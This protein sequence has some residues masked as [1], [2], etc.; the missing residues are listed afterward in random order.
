MNNKGFL[1]VLKNTVVV[2]NTHAAYLKNEKHQQYEIYDSCTHNNPPE[3]RVWSD[4]QPVRKL[5]QRKQ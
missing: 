4:K 5:E 2:S 3:S 1:L